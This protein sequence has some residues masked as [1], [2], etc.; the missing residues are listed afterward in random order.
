MV[1]TN[2]TYCLN[3]HSSEWT[4]KADMNCYRAHHCLIVAHGKLFAVGG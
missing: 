4:Q 1:S 3:I 2:T